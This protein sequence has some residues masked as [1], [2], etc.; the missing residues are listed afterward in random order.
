MGELV[1]ET[2]AALDPL[3]C[4]ELACHGL[5]AAAACCGMA[6][7]LR[8]RERPYNDLWP[9]KLLLLAAVVVW[10]AGLVLG[11][12]WVWRLRR[13]DGI[14]LV[15]VLHVLCAFI[16]GQP[17]VFFGYAWLLVTARAKS[18]G[19]GVR[20]RFL[21]AFSGK[22]PYVAALHALF[23][24][25]SFVH[26]RYSGD[27]ACGGPV[28]NNPYLQE[29][30]VAEDNRTYMVCW[31]LS[32]TDEFFYRVTLPCPRGHDDFV[33]REVLHF[34][35]P[36]TTFSVVWAMYVYF[37]SVV[38]SV[39]PSF[40]NA[41]HAR[42][43]KLLRRM[44]LAATIASAALKVGQMFCLASGSHEADA[45]APGVLRFLGSICD[46]AIALIVTLSIAT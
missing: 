16:V 25:V 45:F 35:L 42:R 46:D 12:T 6:W 44:L 14:R 37:G 26:M 24:S 32:S 3:G 8:R 21:R 43:F 19:T 29:V 10:I 30:A 28:E 13:R 23:L 22:L 1:H 4:I 36:L 34:T 38:W 11:C 2:P 41:A 9:Y 33:G 40:L 31:C 27:Q 20:Q 15:F 7:I 18:F 5:T 17:L 39:V